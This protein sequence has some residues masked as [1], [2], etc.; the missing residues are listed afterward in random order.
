MLFAVTF[1]VVLLTSLLSLIPVNASTWISKANMPTAREDL[2]AIAYNGKIYTFGGYGSSGRLSKVEVYDPSTNSWVTKNPIPVAINNVGAVAIG[3]KIYIMGYDGSNIRF[4]EYNPTDD[5]WTP[6][7][8]PPVSTFGQAGYGVVGNMLYVAYGSWPTGSWTYVYDPSSNTW[9][10]KKPISDI[11]ER[12]IESFAVIG[13]KLYAIGGAEPKA[14]PTEVSRVDVYDPATDSWQKGAIPDMPRRRTHLSPTTPVV[15]GKA[16]VI[17]GWDGWSE[18]STVFVYDTTTNSWSSEAN[19]PTARFELACASIGGSIYALGGDSGGAGGNFKSANEVLDVGPDFIFSAWA[20]VIPTI[21]GILSLGEWDDADSRIFYMGPSEDH[22]ATLYVKND[23]ENLYIAFQIEGVTYGPN[24]PACDGLRIWFDNDNDGTLYENGDDILMQST[25]DLVLSQNWMDDLFYRS[26]ISHFAWDTGF[27]GSNDGS[28]YWTHT[29]PTPNATGVYVFESSHPLNSDDDTH[30][31]SLSLGDEVGFYIE[32]WEGIYVSI[33]PW[34]TRADWSDEWPEDKHAYITLA[35]LPWYSSE[36]VSDDYKIASFELVEDWMWKNCIPLMVLNSESYGYWFFRATKDADTV[37]Q[38]TEHRPDWYYRILVDEN[39]KRFTVQL[40]AHWDEQYA[41]YFVDQEKC[42]LFSGHKWDYE[43]IFLYYTYTNDDFFL[44]LETG[45]I[46]YEYVFHPIGHGIVT[47]LKS[48]LGTGTDAGALNDKKLFFWS[49]IDGKQ[50][51]VFTIGHSFEGGGGTTASLISSALPTS[52]AGHEYGHVRISGRVGVNIVPTITGEQL[53]DDIV[54][55]GYELFYPVEK[56][57]DNEF[58]TNHLKRLTDDII[59]LWKQ[60]AENPFKMIPPQ[61]NDLVNPWNDFYQGQYYSIGRLFDPIETIPPE[62]LVYIQ[63]PI[64][65]HIY[66]PLG[67]HVGLSEGQLEIEIPGAY[68]HPYHPDMILILEP[69]EGSYR[70]ILIGEGTGFYN[71]S[72]VLSN[73]IGDEV[74]TVSY[75][76]NIIEGSVLESII[77]L[78]KAPEGVLN[79]FST[80]PRSLHPVGGIITSVDKLDLYLAIFQPYFVLSVF[81]M[82][83]VMV[84]II[85]NKK[86]N[87]PK[88]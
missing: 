33:D 83:L 46:N 49:D 70:V 13:N 51:P 66:D 76:G 38:E 45:T 63:S 48:L 68:Y 26:E 62:L 28:G 42:A 80:P 56:N 85:I 57:F 54:K 30:D 25:Y 64:D 69:I 15:N 61:S 3:N 2:A 31:F 75:V 24:G 88:K 81:A 78:F 10:S 5:S 60:R 8:T 21:D 4:Y 7:P 52:W 44:S 77:T 65:L 41:W 47:P 36:Y 29:N 27:G 22:R 12:S 53:I 14:P 32:F 40:F 9:S 19:M 17:G 84:I 23:Y 18:Q 20:S 79:G 34:L 55:N 11:A 67:R 87:K 1:V 74:F 43:P 39:N 71:F 72:I 86:V 50:H 6:K 82:S 58:K 59:S 37:L 35:G 16:Y 73:N